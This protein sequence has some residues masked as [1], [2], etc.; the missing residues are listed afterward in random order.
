MTPTGMPMTSAFGL[1][2]D[3]RAAAF[4]NRP[5]DADKLDRLADAQ[6]K[7]TALIR[8]NCLEPGTANLASCAAMAN[9]AGQSL[10]SLERSYGAYTRLTDANGVPYSERFP[11]TVKAMESAIS[12]QKAALETMGHAAEGMEKNSDISA[13]LGN[14]AMQ[15]AGHFIG[16]GDLKGLKPSSATG[17]TTT[18]RAGEEVGNVGANGKVV[19][20]IRTPVT[21]GGTANSATGP[22]LAEQLSNESLTASGA[23]MNNIKVVAEGKVNGQVYVDTNQMARPAT[24]ANA[25]EMTLVPAERVAAREAQGLGNVNGNMATAHA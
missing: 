4:G 11:E 18:A 15:A 17:A 6:L 7:Y 22:K 1:A 12:S 25:S 10:D 23:N 20:E 2:D 13:R 24:S 5:L 8:E 21:S 3:F 14:F 19:G 16:T 9:N